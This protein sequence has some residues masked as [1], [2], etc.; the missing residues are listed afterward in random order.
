MRGWPGVVLFLLA[1][2]I[3]GGV[4]AIAGHASDDA[5]TYAQ[6][7]SVQLEPLQVARLVEKAP[8]PVAG[9]HGTRAVDATCTPGHRDNRRNPWLCRVRYASRRRIGYTITIAPN[10]SFYGVNPTGDRVV[11]G[12]CLAVGE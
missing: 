1:V 6:Q 7:H 5:F 12:C 9:G 11:N 4:V 2:G 10:G 8:E 3:V